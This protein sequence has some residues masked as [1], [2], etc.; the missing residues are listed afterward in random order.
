MLTPRRTET[1]G[2][3]TGR[4]QWKATAGGD[5]GRRRRAATAGGDGGRQSGPP[6]TTTPTPEYGRVVP[7]PTP[8][9]SRE[10]SPPLPNGGRV[11][12]L[13]GG[14]RRR[15]AKLGGD[16]PGKATADGDGSQRVATAGGNSDIVVVPTPPPPPPSRQG[17]QSSSPIPR[18]GRE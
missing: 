7:P 16:S 17:R 4:R 13:H 15:A 14:L 18:V 1:A 3:E 6:P 10:S 11:G 9:Q 12:R 2:G 5:G 8:P